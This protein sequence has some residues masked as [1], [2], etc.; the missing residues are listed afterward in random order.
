VTLSQPHAAGATSASATLRHPPSAQLLHDTGA[1]VEVEELQLG[2]DDVLS[3]RIRQVI[4][5]PLVAGAA[6]VEAAHRDSAETEARQRFLP[7]LEL[8]EEPSASELATFAAKELRGKKIALHASPTSVFA[9]HLSET[10]ASFGCETARLPLE[11]ALHDSEERLWTG[12]GSG[13]ET[14]APRT[15]IALS[16]NKPSLVHYPSDVGMGSQ[17]TSAPGGRSAARSGSETAVLDPVTG[18]P[19]VVRSDAAPKGDSASEGPSALTAPPM[20]RSGSQ[21]VPF[22]F[23]MIDDDIDTLQRELLRMRSAISLLHSAMDSSQ[24]GARPALRRGPPSSNRQVRRLV[25]EDIALSGRKADAAP[26]AERPNEDEDDSTHAII[27]FTSLRNFRMVRDAIQPIVESASTQVAPLPEVIVIPQPAG[28]RR[29]LT[30]MHTAV[31]KPLVDPFFSP[32]ATSP[33]SPVTASRA[34]GG[35]GWQ[36]SGMPSP[37]MVPGRSLGADAPH[38]AAPAPL[39]K[40]SKS[41]D[42]KHGLRLELPPPP[43]MI[44]APLLAAAQQEPTPRQVKPAAAAAAAT[45]PA[46]AERKLASAPSDSVSHGSQPV[47]SEGSQPASMPAVVA[48]GAASAAGGIAAGAPASP[49]PFDA[50]GYFSETAARMGSRGASGM[51]IQSP[52]GRPAG[53]F[54]QPAT[55][56]SHGS[57]TPASQRRGSGENV[58]QAGVSSNGGGAASDGGRRKS[59]SRR[60]TGD[61][62]DVTATPRTTRETHAS[63]G[64]GSRR[65]TQGAGTDGGAAASDWAYPAGSLFSP[66]VGIESVLAGSKPPLATPLDEVARSS[67]VW[68]PK[69]VGIVPSSRLS[70][71]SAKAPSVA[72]AGSAPQPSVHAAEAASSAPASAPAPARE[73]AP[74]PKSPPRI[75][76]PR[77]EGVS[78]APPRKTAK[79]TAPQATLAEPAG[80][81]A[82]LSPTSATSPGS[83]TLPLE[84][85]AH[86]RQSFA[87]PTQPV[88]R[89]PSAQ[90]QSGLLIGAGFAPTVKKGGGPKRA[91]VREKVLPPIK[92]L[93]VEGA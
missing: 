82:T 48:P 28:V 45:A 14:N 11:G 76:L 55:T 15:A 83:P 80:Q 71:A 63:S 16:G 91:P 79:A 13:E 88:P 75:K 7:A 44:S 26:A 32:I 21:I 29:L 39:R 90:P 6:L 67:A 92:V 8:A 73:A 35:A 1:G 60:G 53:I 69:H 24:R 23:I 77:R 41:P 20:T 47:A 36:T 50:L 9:R 89:R 61:A 22:S 64:R 84:A 33:L 70:G 74:E 72:E 65:K 27:Y 81:H 43:T 5:L 42:R 10:L 31:Y 2:P 68:D 18:V 62:T 58:S 40:G 51:V 49:M 57:R 46:P 66:Q 85:A 17:I 4:R 54:F 56:S 34:A 30:A 12:P 38:I 52:D 86:A 19:V 59:E 87:L 93:I 78:V 25:D 3:S 37:G